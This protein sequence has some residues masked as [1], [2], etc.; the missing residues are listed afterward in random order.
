MIEITQTQTVNLFYVIRYHPYIIPH[1]HFSSPLLDSTSAAFTA[2]IVAPVGLVHLLCRDVADAP[3][4]YD[5]QTTYVRALARDRETKQLTSRQLHLQA[6]KV[7]V[8]H[9]FAESAVADVEVAD[10]AYVAPEL[11]EGEEAREL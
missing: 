9:G 2:S 10:P 8:N 1:F 11:A 7:V 3:R 4:A 6:P 5:K